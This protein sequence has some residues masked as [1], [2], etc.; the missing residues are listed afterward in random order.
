[1]PVVMDVPGLFFAGSAIAM[2][3][4]RRIERKTIRGESRYVRSALIFGVFYGLSVAFPSFWREDWMWSYIIRPPLPTMIWYLFYVA[5]L[6]TSAWTGANMTQNA[7]SNG[8]RDS[9]WRILASGGAVL[10]L[11]WLLV[12]DRYLVVGTYEE[13]HS[14]DAFPI[15]LMPDTRTTILIGVAINGAILLLISSYN[16]W[17]D[18]QDRR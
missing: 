10:V 12:L 7:L 3:G 18:Y 5:V 6:C 8:R 2:S 14:G 4:R 13:Y 9:A 16:L 1:M 15:E 11:V 17:M